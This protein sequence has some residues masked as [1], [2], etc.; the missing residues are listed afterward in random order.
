MNIENAIIRDESIDA[1]HASAAVSSSN[2]GTWDVSGPRAFYE[3][4]VARETRRAR[5]KALDFG[6]CFEDA[7]RGDRSGWVTPPDDL[8]RAKN[9]ALSTKE[10]R[11]WKAAQEAAGLAILTADEVEAIERGIEG[12]QANSAACDLI[13]AC[14]E[15][16]TLRCQLAELPEI[17]GIQA[18]PDFFG[19]GGSYLSSYVPI[20]PDLKTTR[21]PV[22]KFGWRTV[23]KY[24]YDRQAALVRK[25]CRELGIGAVRHPLIVVEKSY[26]FACKVWWIP[27]RMVDHA[28]ERVDEMLSAIATHYESGKWPLVEDE[29]GEIKLPSW[30][31]V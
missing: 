16:V 10:A 5:T 28:E 18:R 27:T 2:L 24:G 1:Y 9:G 12:L 17:P 4:H 11:E 14:E 13:E 7:L 30:M 23:T 15:Q 22:K 31:E 6:Q 25:C 3:R 21:D 29:Q 20:A 26:P 19:Q 8:K